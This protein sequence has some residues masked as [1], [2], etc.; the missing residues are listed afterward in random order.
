MSSNYLV[1][2]QK[3]NQAKQKKG[4]EIFF[5]DTNKDK[6]DQDIEADIEKQ[7]EESEKPKILEE[8]NNIHKKKNY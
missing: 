3:K 8:E 6:I 5:H 4:F 1:E 2:L 7:I